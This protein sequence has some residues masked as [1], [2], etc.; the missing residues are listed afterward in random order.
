MRKMTLSTVTVALVASCLFLLPSPSAWSG[1]LGDGKWWEI[2]RISEQLG[3]THE[4]AERINEIWIEHRKQLIDTRGEIEKAYL[5]LEN[6]LGKTTVETQQAYQLAERLGQLHAKQAEQRL[7]MTID[8]RQVLSV[9][10]FEK[11]KG[12]RATWAKMLT[13]K[14]I[15]EPRK[16]QSAPE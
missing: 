2:P 3:L 15:Q 10:Q 11:L 6:L 9:E 1:P 7:K 12:M 5:D 8:T 14:R 4:Q 16:R 13:E